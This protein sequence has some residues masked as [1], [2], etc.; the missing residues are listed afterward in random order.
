MEGPECCG[1]FN[2]TSSRTE[3]STAV[4]IANQPYVIIGA[5]SRGQCTA[6]APFLENVWF[7]FFPGDQGAR[8][9]LQ[10]ENVTGFEAKLFSKLPRNLD[11]AVLTQNRVH[12]RKV[13]ARKS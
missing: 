8:L 7:N 11:V 6:P 1:S 5:H 12:A 13:R 10:F 4:T 9:I 3:V 2:S